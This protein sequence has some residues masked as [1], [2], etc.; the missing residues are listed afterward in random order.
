MGD[1]GSFDGGFISWMLASQ[2]RENP[3]ALCLWGYGYYEFLS[4]RVEVKGHVK[5]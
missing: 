2:E 3:G 4:R 5:H 1:C